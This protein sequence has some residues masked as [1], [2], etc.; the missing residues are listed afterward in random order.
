M[1]DVIRAWKD[2]KYY[3]S[4][5]AEQRQS[6]PEKPA[7]LIELADSDIRQVFGGSGSTNTD[8]SKPRLS[9]TN[10]STCNISIESTICNTYGCC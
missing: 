3:R 10:A 9:C 5:T 4:L 2:E 6:L 7:G 8:C 1:V